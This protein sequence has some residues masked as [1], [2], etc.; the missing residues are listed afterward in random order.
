MARADQANSKPSRID[1]TDLRHD[2]D[3]QL[4]VLLGAG[5]ERNLG[6]RCGQ[7]A[8]GWF[9]QVGEVADDGNDGRCDFATRPA[10]NELA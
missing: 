5:S 7:I 6:G 10:T 8:D 1:G 9:A 4:S 2:D 3:K